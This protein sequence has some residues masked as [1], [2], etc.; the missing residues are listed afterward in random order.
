MKVLVVKMSSMGDIVHTLPAIVEA[1]DKIPD[2]SFH[3]V[4]EE[5]FKDI[6]GIHPLVDKVIPLAIRRWRKNF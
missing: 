5:G 1:M 3:W 6:P 2:I 4:V